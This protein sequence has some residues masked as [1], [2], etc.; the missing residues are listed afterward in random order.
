[1]NERRGWVRGGARFSGEIR[2]VT[3]K[4][5]KTSGRFQPRGRAIT[6]GVRESINI[7]QADTI[8]LALD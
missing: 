7:F 2:L 1:M 3:R 4:S 6:C 5:P 8:L